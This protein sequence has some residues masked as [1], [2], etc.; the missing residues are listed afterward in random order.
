MDKSVE[1]YNLPKPNQEE[2]EGLNNQTLH[3]QKVKKKLQRHP[4]AGTRKEISKIRLEA[5]NI[6]TKSTI[7]RINESRSWFLEKINKIDKPLSRLIKKKRED[8]H[9]HNQK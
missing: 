8:P 2:V 9:K 5:N 3:L 7:L 1:I 4:T 6:E